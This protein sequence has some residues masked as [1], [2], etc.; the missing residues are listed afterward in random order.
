MRVY[1]KQKGLW[2]ANCKHVVAANKSKGFEFST[3]SQN[4]KHADFAILILSA[5][6][7]SSSGSSSLGAVTMPGEIPT[8][9]PWKCIFVACFSNSR[10]FIFG[11][12]EI[13]FQALDSAVVTATKLRP[14][15]CCFASH[16]FPSSFPPLLQSLL[17]AGWE[18]STATV[19][20]IWHH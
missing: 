9:H 6:S 5:I 12:R 8:P 3:V 18:V 13:L 20:T 19:W 17:A 11:I 7:M 16:I 10:V 1:K 4:I 15:W 2:H 14:K